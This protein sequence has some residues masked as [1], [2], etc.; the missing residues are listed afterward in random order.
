MRKRISTVLMCLVMVLTLGTGSVVWA[1]DETTPENV[2]KAAPEGAAMQETVVAINSTTFPDKNF[3]KWVV[4]NIPGAADYKLTA[5]EID[6]V[7]SM[8]CRDDDFDYNISGLTGIGYFTSLEKLDCGGC[9]GRQ[10]LGC[11]GD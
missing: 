4:A 10:W 11:E 9:L 6:A 2:G 1:E 5:E 3:R 7:T 8:D